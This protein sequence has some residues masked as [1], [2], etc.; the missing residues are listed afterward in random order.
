MPPANPLTPLTW[1]FALWR[2]TLDAATELTH[3]AAVADERLGQ[4]GSASVGETPSEV[5]YRENKLTLSRYEPL[6]DAQSPVPLLVVYALINRPYVLD[7]QPNRS[8][9]RRLLEAGH[10]VYLVD[11]G[12]PS[13][14]D[15]SLTLADYVT[16]YLDNCVDA[17]RDRSEQDSIN[18]LGYCMGGTMAA[19]YTALY[20]EKVNALGLLAT[21]LHFD[22][23]G[24]LLER[25][26]DE[27]YFDPHTIPETF[28]NV[29]A[30]FLAAGFAAMDPV[31]NGVSKYV[32]LYDHLENE[33]FV[34]NFGRMERW[35]ADGI[36]VAGDAY[37]EFVE[38]IYQ[39]NLLSKNELELGGRHVDLS[40]I[41]APVLQI[42]G[43]YDHLVPPT[44]STPFNDAVASDDVTT[45]EYPT[46][47]IGLSVSAAA[48][49]DL[50][51]EVA[52]WFHEQ[53]LSPSSAD[54]LG[55]G[56]E[57]LLGV[58][59][60]TDVTVGDVDEVAVSVA[61][62]DG[63]ITRDVVGRNA[64]AVRRFVETVLDVTIRLEPEADGVRVVV[65]HDDTVESTL[66]TGVSDAIRREVEES[67][68]DRDV[69]AGHALQE[70]SGIGPTYERRL[71][72]GGIER[73]ADLAAADAATIAR[74]A[75]VTEQ[76]ARGWISQAARLVA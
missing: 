19:M 43:S 10:D 50:W 17:V 40:R 68:E 70:V 33:D 21:G 61:D 25:W 7:L 16:R 15:A 36:D 31:A 11:W 29:P 58:D 59:V 37:S 52:E 14:L 72:E 66:V 23:T 20:P 2:S 51:P 47:H 54:V 22:G 74:V 69:A 4:L 73:V 60:E 55:E 65:E 57:R 9:V 24:G 5:V 13:R 28:G 53:S 1:P 44:A 8:V 26:G 71:R 34:A 76:M 64:T 67:I 35:L 32:S 3:R 30:E 42:V 12:E 45:V 75:D 38:S 49:R 6:T 46:G 18:L 41:E 39:R 27:A 56:V 63:T 48:H 62:A